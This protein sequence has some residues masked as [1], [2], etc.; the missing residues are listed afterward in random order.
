MPRPRKPPRLWFREERRGD[1]GKLIS[2]GTWLILDGGEQI[3]TGCASG[4]EE[5]ANAKL[6]EHIA[7]SYRE[8]RRE[9]D[10]ERIPIS[11][12]LAIYDEDAREAQA[13]TRIFDAMVDRLNA[14]W[15]GM[16]LAE[17][18]GTS[19]RAYMAF[20]KKEGKRGGPGGARRDLETLR[21]AINH[22]AK[23]GLHRGVVRV[24]LPEKGES[25]QQ[26]MTRSEVAKLLWYCWRHRE[27]QRRHRGADAG[28]ELPTSKYPLRHI[29]RFI[30]LGVY[31]GTRAAAIASASPVEAEG[32]SWVDLN[33]GIY[34]RLAKGKKATNKRQPPAKLPPHLLAH[35]RRWR[36][37]DE[38]KAK[39]SN[40]PAP[41]HFV[42]WNGKPVL[43]VKTGFKSAAVGAKLM[44]KEA[45]VGE[46]LTPHT[47]R[48]TAATWLMQNAVPTWEAAGFLGMDEGTLRR[49]YGHHHPDFQQAAA[50]GFRPKRE[51]H[52]R[53]EPPVSL[54]KSLETESHNDGK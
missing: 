50:L 22:H 25:R 47:L 44:D 35:M 31:T 18:T 9:R 12:V 6:A 17:V 2:S 16:M 37:A 49:V 48:H 26:W 13:N 41:T 10:I 51:P 29:A 19:C 34:Y 3:A 4:E 28:R 40:R 32:R 20:R 42:E 8:P 38:R 14:W 7:S 24:W 33:A 5:A 46:R 39:A 52:K 54:E 21:A 43:S 36:A 11:S 15:G 30:L 23:E 27:T 45:P 1:G 53:P